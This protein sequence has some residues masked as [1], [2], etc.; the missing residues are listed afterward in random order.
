MRGVRTVKL[1]VTI[2]PA[3]TTSMTYLPNTGLVFPDF[4]GLESEIHEFH[5][6]PGFQ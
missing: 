4:P 1:L 3:L 5:D 6:F 2:F